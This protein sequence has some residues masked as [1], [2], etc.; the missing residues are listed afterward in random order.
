MSYYTTN[1]GTPIFLNLDTVDR[2][3]DENSEFSEEALQALNLIRSTDSSRP[4]KSEHLAA[5]D[6]VFD[7][8]ICI[9]PYTIFRLPLHR[10]ICRRFNEVSEL[11]GDLREALDDAGAFVFLDGV[12]NRQ[13]SQGIIERVLAVFTASSIGVSKVSDAPPD[14]VHAAVDFF[15]TSDGSGWHSD[16]LRRNAVAMQC[17]SNVITGLAHVFNDNTLLDKARKHRSAS[18]GKNVGWHAFQNSTDT[19]DQELLGFF[20]HFQEDTRI[21]PNVAHAAIIN[22]ASW[23]KELFPNEQVRE[24]VLSAHRPE[25][26]AAF[27][28]RKNGGKLNHSILATVEASRRLAVSINEQLAEQVGGKA[29]FDLISQ[30]EVRTIRNEIAKRPTPSRTRSRPLPEKLIPIMKD[31]LEEG[32]AGWPGRTFTV[33]IIRDGV[34]RKLYCPVIPSLFRAMLD[35]PLRMGQIRRLDSGEGDVR[36]FD[37]DTMKWLENKSPLAGFWADLAGEPWENFPTRGYAIEIEDEIKPITGIWANTNKTGQ[38]WAIPWFIPGLMKN[39]WELRKWQEEFNPIKAP[40]GPETYLD[41]PERYSEK[42]KAEM[43]QIFPLSRLLPNRYWPTPGRIVTGSEMDHA[44]CSLLLEIQL[45]W[46]DQHPGNKVTLVDIHPKT[47]QPYRPRYNI[48]GLRVRGLT[49]LRRGRMPLDLLSKF[50]AGHANIMTTIYYTEPHP[51]EIA[52]EIDKAVARFDTQHEFINELKRMEVDE[53]RK[54]TVSISESAVSSAIESGSQFQFCNV[55]IGLCPYDGSRCSDGG[56]LLRKEE[57]REGS[58][59][60]YGPVEPRNCVM[61]RHFISGPPWLNELLEYGTKLCERRQY[62]ARE[63]EKINGAAGQYE[64]A[65]RDGTIGSAVFESRWEE[66]GADVQQVKNEQEMVENAI[67]NVELLC[68]AS[69]KLLDGDPNGETGIM[70]VANNRSSVMEYREVSEFEQAV[71]ITAAGRVHRI[72]GDERVERKRDDYLNLML[73][74]S[75]VISPQM[76]TSV[77]REHRQMAMDQ[78][79]LFMSSRISPEEIDGLVEGTLHLRDLGIE[80]EVRSLIDVA[81]SEPILLPGATR[82]QERLAVGGTA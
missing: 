66:L 71:R 16:V 21:R 29:L 11:G 22:V 68:N 43:P 1:N 44:W 41:S 53:A 62:L 80:E 51:S 47:R 69:V 37:G 70:L 60:V 52:D 7:E 26:F 67:F 81:L 48:H 40:I 12:H 28:K 57:S 33:D 64:H 50:I 39:L 13:H 34:A 8:E 72:L 61:C 58:K 73:F 9:S 56:I 14:F 31:I 10:D 38:P 36:H 76:I 82:R 42:T 79:A 77:S 19:L 27:M 32:A 63:E 20:P 46:N 18:A 74:N 75:G 23:M 24:V 78:Y 5:V 6:I 25:S 54:R 65:H 17:V 35:I 3:Y 55:A 45:R 30:K 59:S 4:I 49:N 2:K 15:R